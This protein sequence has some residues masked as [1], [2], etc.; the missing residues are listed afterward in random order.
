MKKSTWIKLHVYGGL[1]TCWYLVAFGVSSLIL[2]HNMD[3]NKDAIADSWTTQVTYDPADSNL[4][5][6][7]R[8]RDNLNLM[9]WIPTWQIRKDSAYM[10]FKITHLGKTS[11]LH[12]ALATGILQVNERPKGMMAVL[13]G[14]H[15]FNGNIPNA[16][17]LLRT[18]MV[19]QWLALFV[20]LISLIIGIWLW[21]RYG[22]KTW[23]LYVFGGLFLIS[24]VLMTL[25]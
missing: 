1:F 2:N 11:D 25:I 17:F 22:Y 10:D 21:I 20:F 6:A 23:E 9:G 19:Y 4:D 5:N 12:L 16:P 3:V 13:H 14:L 15:F 24:I 8:I 7:T 18:W